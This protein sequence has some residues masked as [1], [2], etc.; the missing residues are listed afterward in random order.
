MSIYLWF[1]ELKIAML[2]E[3]STRDYVPQCG[4][5]REKVENLKYK[6]KLFLSWFLW[7]LFG[8]IMQNGYR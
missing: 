2:S 5:S 8:L 7:H 4:T 6:E 1:E 3:V